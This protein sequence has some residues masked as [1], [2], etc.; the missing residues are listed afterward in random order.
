MP[1][2]P[3]N[4]ARIVLRS[5]VARISPTLASVCFC[6]RVAWSYSTRE[7]TPSFHQLLHAAEIDSRQIALR[8]EGGQLRP[9]LPRIELDQDVSLLHGLAGI[10]VDLRHCTRQIGAD[11]H[12]V[13]RFHRADHAHGR[14]PLLLLRH[15]TGHRFRRGLKWPKPAPPSA[16]A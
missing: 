5:M 15:H 3:E 16:P 4:G 13:N 12:A 11:H 7:I 6:W 1:R 8:L 14:G 2:T 9:L 10:E